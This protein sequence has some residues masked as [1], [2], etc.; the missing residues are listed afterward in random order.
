[1]TGYS[2]FSHA[3]NGNVV[4]E[5]STELKQLTVDAPLG[6]LEDTSLDAPMQVARRHV[7]SP[8]G[9]AVE[10]GLGLG[11]QFKSKQTNGKMP[12]VLLDKLTIGR[13]AKVIENLARQRD[14]LDDEIKAWMINRGA[15]PKDGWCLVLPATRDYDLGNLSR[16]KYVIFTRT[17]EKPYLAKRNG[18]G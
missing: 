10:A 13:M 4:I 9:W 1:M 17:T 7:R 12:R 16:L 8:K 11:S 2:I 15:D 6:N 5:E 14:L 18:R 3:Q